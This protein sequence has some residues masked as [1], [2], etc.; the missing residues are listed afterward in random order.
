MTIR[1]LEIFAEVCAHMNMSKAAQS[2]MISQSSVSQA[3]GALEREYQ[4]TL[5]ERL[6]HALYLTEAG[7]QM[8]YLTLQILQDVEY[9]RRKMENTSHR[10]TISM[11]ACTTVGTCL[12]SPLLDRYKRMCGDAQV[13]VE[14]NNSR[15]LEKKVLEAKLDLAIVQSMETASCLEHIPVWTDELAVICRADHPLAGKEVEWEQ[16]GKELFVGREEGSGTQQVLEQAFRERGMALKTGWICNGI[17]AVK[18]AVA[19]GAGIG[20]VSRLLVQEE[21][22]ENGLDVIKI[23]DV[24]LTRQF[25]LIFHRDKIPDRGF[26]QLRALCTELGTEG[27]QHMG[28]K[29]GIEPHQGNLRLKA[30]GKGLQA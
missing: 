8:R 4:V 13:R 17:D 1:S 3:I 12:I 11:G 16:L 7:E 20:L 30:A 21:G 15:S 14:I 27:V 5:F 22:K 2:M 10:Q 25:D 19:Y 18:Q 24:L 29:D 26:C 28:R 9:M 23:K 6:N